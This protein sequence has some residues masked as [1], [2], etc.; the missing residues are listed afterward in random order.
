MGVGWPCLN[1]F[2]SSS[3]SFAPIFF[4]V[5]FKE[6]VRS[7]YRSKE[8]MALCVK[9]RKKIG[10]SLGLSRSNADDV[11]LVPRHFLIAREKE[12]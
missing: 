4:F 12:K 8:H 7:F 11:R 3:F 2:F 9:A 1:I 5:A 10:R 6:N